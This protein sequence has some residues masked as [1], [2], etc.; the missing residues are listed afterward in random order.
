MANTLMDCQIVR[1]F[2]QSMHARI[3][4]PLFAYDV[5]TRGGNHGGMPEEIAA[6][7]GIKIEHLEGLP[8]LVKLEHLKPDMSDPGTDE[9]SKSAGDALDQAQRSSH[10]P[11]GLANHAPKVCAPTHAQHHGH[12]CSLRIPAFA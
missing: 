3:F 12:P 6:F 5:P 10:A 9:P 11:L 8:T 1:Q 7:F 2:A 4:G